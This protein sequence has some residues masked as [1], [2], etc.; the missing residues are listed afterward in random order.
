MEIKMST[1]TI[2]PIRIQHIK[3]FRDTLDTVAREK[4]Y[5]A[6][7]EAPPLEAVRHFILEN[8]R[9]DITQYVALDGKKVVGWCDIIWP[10]LPGFAHCGRLGMGLLPAYRGQGLGRR[11][12]ETCLADAW[13]KGLTRIELDVYASNQAAI[14]LY[15]QL[16]FVHEGRKNNA[17]FLDGLYDDI[18]LMAIVKPDK[19]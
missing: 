6:F 7:L 4:K 13:H 11:L 8:L 17:R 12:A 15:E 5:L 3:S 14:H 2:S 9:R 19:I 16:G 1:I 10:E 18:L